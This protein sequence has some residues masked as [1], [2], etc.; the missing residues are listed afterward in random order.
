M[1]LIHAISL[2]VVRQIVALKDADLP[3]IQPAEPP[4]INPEPSV[5]WETVQLN[6]FLRAS[7][8]DGRAT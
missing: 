1:I 5:F 2:A 7:S 6:E 4:T 8:P 3:I